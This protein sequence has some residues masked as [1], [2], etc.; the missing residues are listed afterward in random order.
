V[1][2]QPPGQDV[3][4]R[5]FKLVQVGT[6]LTGQYMDTKGKKY[7]LSGTLEGSNVRLVVQ[8]PD[9]STILMEGTVDG[10]TDML[11]MLT[12]SKENVPFTAAYRAKEKWSD[13][14]NASP[15][16]LTGLGSGSGNPYP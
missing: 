16:G 14:V 10:T 5:H 1:Q 12:D 3:E 11:G 9:G 4:Y 13:N 8:L 15:G 2:I 6:Q 7:P